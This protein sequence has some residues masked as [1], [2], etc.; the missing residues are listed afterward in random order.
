MPAGASRGSLTEEDVEDIFNAM[1]V[2]K[3]ETRI[4]W[5]EF[6]AAG[7]SQCHF[8]DRNLRLAFDRVDSDHK[9]VSERQSDFWRMRFFGHLLHY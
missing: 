4:H 5:H 2:R 9:G 1:R 6:I 7:L 3:T 8:D